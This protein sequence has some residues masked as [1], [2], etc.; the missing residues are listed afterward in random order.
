MDFLIRGI[1]LVNVVIAPA[2]V[3]TK[4][5]GNSCFFILKNC[6][7]IYALSTFF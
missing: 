3:L 6:T 4:G 7:Y 5:K 2:V 1:K